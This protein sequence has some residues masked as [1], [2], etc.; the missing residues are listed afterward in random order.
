VQQFVLDSRESRFYPGIA[1][2][3]FG[4]VDPNN[5]RTLIVE[6]H[7]QDYARTITM[8]IPAQHERGAPAPFIVSCVEIRLAGAAENRRYV[9]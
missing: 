9:R 6:T 3:V 8:N 5:P 2:E 1:R 4:T 7:P